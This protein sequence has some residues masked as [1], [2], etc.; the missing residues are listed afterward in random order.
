MG[1]IQ[2]IQTTPEQLVELIN[3]G[4]K[5]QLEDFKKELTTKEAN[6][7]L[8]TRKEACEFLKIDSSTLWA[9]S[10]KGKVKAY[11]IVNRRYYKR[12]ELIESLILVK[13]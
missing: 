8:L 11:G 9:W 10:N 3:E 12:N 2:L 7:E 1:T 13:K 5:K 4:V 6:D